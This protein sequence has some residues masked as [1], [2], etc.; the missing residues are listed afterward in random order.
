M[1]KSPQTDKYRND[2]SYVHRDYLTV[3]E[4]IATYPSTGVVNTSLLHVREGAGTSYRIVGALKLNT[5]VQ[6]NS[7]QGDWYE[8]TYGPWKNAKDSDVIQYLDPSK[9]SVGSSEFFQFLVLSQNAGIGAAE[10]N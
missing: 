10:I 7:T 5:T 1:T 9:F 6:I 4:P 3:T 2:K 8:I